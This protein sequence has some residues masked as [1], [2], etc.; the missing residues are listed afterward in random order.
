M[1]ICI[2]DDSLNELGIVDEFSSLIWTMRFYQ[3]GAFEL[4][5]PLTENNVLLLQKN[6][7][8]YRP[9]VEE[10]GIIKSIT[11]EISDGGKIMTVSG[12][13]LNGLLDK[14]VVDKSFAGSGT[15]SLYN[16]LLYSLCASTSFQF[17]PCLYFSSDDPMLNEIILSAKNY[18]NL[19][20]SVR[21]AV[22]GSGYSLNFRLSPKNKLIYVGSQ[23]SVDR[24]IEQKDV[25]Q[26]IFSSEFG[27]ISDTVY[28]YSEEGCYNYIRVRVHVDSEI[29]GLRGKYP[30]KDEYIANESGKI[31]RYLIYDLYPGSENGENESKGIALSV[32]IAECDPIII[33][34]QVEGAV[35]KYIDLDKTYAVMRSEAQSYFNEFTENFSGTAD[36]SGY[37]SEWDLGDYV[38]IEDTARKKFYKKQIEEVTEIFEGDHRSVSV[39]FGENLKTILDTMKG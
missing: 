16:V 30:Y 7:Y 27:N 3:T 24:S 5:A 38:S 11:E 34:E 1:E 18:S 14:R 21:S 9:D 39:I 12:S 25:P 8:I 20:E 4:K 22:Y 19:G 37:R 26:V 28:N 35:R 23:K 2:F 32:C 17:V 29:A 10:A 31:E 36:G 33:E 13:M 15:V 6:R